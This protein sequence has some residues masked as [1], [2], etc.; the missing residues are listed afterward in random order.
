MIA[1]TSICYPS[2]MTSRKALQTAISNVAVWRKGD[3]FAPHKP[4]LLLYVLSQYL[5]GHSRLFD[6]GQE[7]HEPLTKLLTD[8]GPKR[9][10]YY[11]NM[12]F[13]RLRTDGFWT[14]SEERRVGKE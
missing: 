7:I 8:F 13:W 4:L 5:N 1:R 3:Q 6:Y 2:A 10:D 12:P 11:P 14:R 9:R